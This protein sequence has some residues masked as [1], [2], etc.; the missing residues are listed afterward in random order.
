[1]KK[2]YIAPKFLRKQEFRDVYR[3]EENKSIKLQQL[4]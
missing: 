3:Y 1:M 4:V 2:K